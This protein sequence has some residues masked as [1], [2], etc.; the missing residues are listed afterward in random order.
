MMYSDIM[1]ENIHELAQQSSPRT[2][3]TTPTAHTHRPTVMH[4]TP[5][6]CYEL[7][8]MR[9]LEALLANPEVI[10]SL[11]DGDGEKG[12]RILVSQHKILNDMLVGAKEGSGDGISHLK[13]EH[14]HSK[15]RQEH[16]PGGRLFAKGSVSL[17]C[18]KKKLRH[19]LAAGIYTDIDMVNAHPTLLVQM[20]NKMGV[21]VETMYPSLFQYVNERET[22]FQR[23][24]DL[25]WERDVAKQTVLAVLF[26]GSG[27]GPDG[28]D[29]RAPPFLHAFIRECEAIR[30]VISDTYPNRYKIY[31]EC[32]S[33]GSKKRKKDA[34]SDHEAKCRLL[35]SI[36]NDQE[37]W[38]LRV[39]IDHMKERGM[40]V[41]NVVPCHDGFM[42][43]L[44]ELRGGVEA[45]M[46]GLSQRVL[47]STGYDIRFVE[48]P[49]DKAIPLDGLT[50]TKLVV[51]M[52]C[53]SKDPEAAIKIVKRFFEGRIKRDGVVG[54]MYSFN[55]NE[56]NPMWIPEEKNWKS[57][58]SSNAY[59]VVRDAIVK[60][61]IKLLDKDGNETGPPSAEFIHTMI[62]MTIPEIE[63]DFSKKARERNVGKFFFLDGRVYEVE[64]GDFRNFDREN[65]MTMLTINNTEPVRNEEDIAKV[66]EVCLGFF[67]GDQE[68][69]ECFMKCMARTMAGRYGDKV[70]YIN[71][72]D[73]H[74][75]KTALVEML[76]EV[77]GD[78]VGE[79]NSS[80]LLAA[81]KNDS[82]EEATRL[83]WADQLSTKR[84][85]VSEEL[86]KTR[87]LDGDK[88]KKIVS[89]GKQLSVRVQ[90]ERQKNI[91]SQGSLMFCCNDLGK[92]EPADCLQE[93]RVF[94]GTKSYTF[95][96][97][98]E[99][100]KYGDD[101]PP[102]IRLK[103]PHLKTKMSQKWFKDAAFFFIM[104]FYQDEKVTPTRRMKEDINSLM[105]DRGFHDSEKFGEIFEVTKDM[106]HSISKPYLLE[107]INE[108][109]PQSSWEKIKNLLIRKGAVLKK[110]TKRCPV[111]G[112]SHRNALLGVR[113]RA[114]PAEVP[115]FVQEGG[116]A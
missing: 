39:C 31:R 26:G 91:L 20:L 109:F 29:Q 37:A 116:G 56:K 4:A 65:D 100:E 111:K 77:F 68:E 92:V 72:S 12:E 10:Q 27:K 64:A 8:D 42:L 103:D 97:R 95:V 45:F 38:V 58:T 88:I 59:Q 44:R 115:L 25:G 101:R 73:R 35:S 61:G 108:H 80:S 34:T 84:L 82:S 5:M 67:G 21:G 40:S 114:Q 86:T 49:M 43:P 110:E 112:G 90:Y 30:N 22:I 106:G 105:E 48:K 71:V 15:F 99:Y 81:S 107:I 74:A 47:E 66:R 93:C 24:V 102:H 113:V 1:D 57:D 11:G 51:G 2:S 19:T 7:L 3:S 76:I 23:F 79:F 87:P 104:S 28:G 63:G 52:S 36:L 55:I 83:A 89:G 69:M 16:F 54:P 41:D 85:L 62:K 32:P 46:Q 60:S 53:Y 6:T 78:L 33:D 14:V 17:Q 18:L 94:G 13:V 70:W 9:R 98:E 75:G 96:D 50:H